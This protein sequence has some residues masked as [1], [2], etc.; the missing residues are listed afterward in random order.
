MV[1]SICY[2][3]CAIQY[4]IDQW[5]MVITKSNYYKYNGIDDDEWL[6]VGLKLVWM[7]KQYYILKSL[8]VS[9]SFPGFLFYAF[10]LQERRR[11]SLG[12]YM[13]INTYKPQQW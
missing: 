13:Y 4:Y 7:K 12:L 10:A 11:E 9:T 6:C 2:T 5:L 8:H 3:G 1:G